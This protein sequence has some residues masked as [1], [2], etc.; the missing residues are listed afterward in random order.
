MSLR[1]FFPKWK[2]LQSYRMLFS[3]RHIVHLNSNYFHFH[4]SFIL[5]LNNGSKL[6]VKL[7]LLFNL[8]LQ[9][10]LIHA[11]H[12]LLVIFL[13]YFVILKSAKKLK[14]CILIILLSVPQGS[15]YPPVRN[16]GRCITINT[17]PFS[18]PLQLFIL[19]CHDGLE[20][21]FHTFL[22]ILNLILL[23]LLSV[24]S[25]HLFLYFR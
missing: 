2:P 17:V 4:H 9:R 6:N 1:F 20:A 7:L 24:S 11:T 12:F 25:F 14:L 18:H 23:Y 10:R 3:F 5:S 8:F 13:G 16:C 21:Y 22:N 19:I 15:S